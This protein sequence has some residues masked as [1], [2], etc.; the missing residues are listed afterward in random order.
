MGISVIP[1]G[2]TLSG[3]ESSRSSVAGRTGKDC[4]T[5]GILVRV[6]VLDN[7]SWPASGV[8]WHDLPT[9]GLV[10]CVGQPQCKAGV[11]L[12]T[13]DVLHPGSRS[14]K[15]IAAPS[16]RD[17]VQG[18]CWHASRGGEVRGLPPAARLGPAAPA[19]LRTAL[20]GLGLQLKTSL[21]QHTWTGLHCVR[22]ESCPVE[23][24]KFAY[25]PPGA[26]CVLFCPNF[27]V[28]SS[29][30]ILSVSLPLL[31]PAF[32]V[33]FS[34]RAFLVLPHRSRSSHFVAVLRMCSSDHLLA[35]GVS[36]PFPGIHFLQPLG[37]H[38]WVGECWKAFGELGW[39]SQACGSQ[40]DLKRSSS[41]S[42]RWYLLLNVPPRKGDD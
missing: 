1:L 2:I 27:L 26:S 13:G 31:L 19:A 28:N 22:Q 30:H 4:E 14:W 3:F 17:A 12:L 8:F 41:I 9:R 5:E 33:R 35:S 40:Q 21:W 6:Q 38:W 24:R 36:S 23:T 32:P 29:P 16:R 20:A 25:V 11:C 37:S 10:S 34:M 7:I 18:I 15:G 42:V 39:Q